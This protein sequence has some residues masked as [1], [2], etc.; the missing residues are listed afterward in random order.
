MFSRCAQL[1]L[2]RGKGSQGGGF[3]TVDTG[4]LWS[5]EGLYTGDEPRLEAGAPGRRKDEAFL[6]LLLLL[7]LFHLY[8]RPEG[9]GWQ[10]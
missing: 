9:G 4:G 6:S 5:W 8:Q 7:I 1:S 2:A 3:R 10:D